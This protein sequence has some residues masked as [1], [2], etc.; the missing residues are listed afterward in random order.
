MTDPI[1]PREPNRIVRWIVIS[2]I[3]VGAFV[4]GYLVREPVRRLTQRSSAAA[5]AE[6]QAKQLWTCGMH[7]QVIQDHPGECPIYGRYQHQVAHYI[8]IYN[9]SGAEIGCAADQ[10]NSGVY[11]DRSGYLY[12]FN[13]G[14]FYGR[15][16][17]RATT[18]T[19]AMPTSCTYVINRMKVVDWQQ[20][21]HQVQP[22]HRR[23]QG[24]EAVGDLAD[25]A[26]RPAP[27]GAVRSFPDGDRRQ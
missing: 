23:R 14:T 20:Y 18:F 2:A 5:A 1:P 10:S 27:P 15:T 4:A 8:M 22:H 7:P 17:T 6:L 16:L 26:V 24:Q 25:R 11:T 13:T 12:N 9:S 21:D 19:S 3:C